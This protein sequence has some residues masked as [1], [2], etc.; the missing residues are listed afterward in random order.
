MPACRL[1]LRPELAA[2]KGLPFLRPR[3]FDPYTFVGSG[4]AY[5]IEGQVAEEYAK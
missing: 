4:N 3:S 5:Y 1:Q 2:Y